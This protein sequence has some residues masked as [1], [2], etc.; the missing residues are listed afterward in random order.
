VLLMKD[1]SGVVGH[2]GVG[3]LLGRLLDAR[4][5]VRVH[6]VGHSYG[7]KVVLSALCSPAVTRSVRSVLLLQPALSYLAFAADVPD[8]H[9]P[10]GYRPATT[11]SELPV[12]VTWSRHDL[13]LRTAFSLAVRR[14]SDLGEQDIGAAGL[15]T[16][17]SRFAAMGGWGPQAGADVADV[18]IQTPDRG[19]YD[20]PAGR[21]VVA[22][23]GDQ[24]IGGHSDV[25]NDATGWALYDLMSRA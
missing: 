25:V 23:E 19:P 13:A 24:A 10:G 3:P 5:G 8:R 15:E 14:Q 1:R 17:P 7:C 22:L 4:P 6:L 11:R 2:R 12:M 20:V 18:R 21:R 16:P 9:G